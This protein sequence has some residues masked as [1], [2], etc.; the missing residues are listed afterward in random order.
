[1]EVRI[2]MTETVKKWLGIGGRV[3][4]D[5]MIVLVAH[6]LAFQLRVLEW[7]PQD[8]RF[9]IIVMA[10]VYI[11][12][13]TLFGIYQRLWEHASLYE[14]FVIVKTIGVSIMLILL[15][16]TFWP[17][18]PRRLSTLA[19]M[20]GGLFAM[21]G[22]I[23]TRYHWRVF[24][25]VLMRLRPHHGDAQRILI[26]GADEAGQFVAQ[27]IRE[28]RNR[29]QYK[30]LGFLDDNP[31]KIDRVVLGMRVL[32]RC[33]EVA[34]WASRM[35]ADTLIIALHGIKRSRLH[36]IIAS[37]QETSARVQISP[38]VL[39]FTEPLSIRDITLD[40]MI[41]RQ[42]VAINDEE[43]R[44]LISGKKVLVTGVGGSIGS[45]LARQLSKFAPAHLFLLDNN[46]TALYDLS[47][48]LRWA[49]P[50][51]QQT[52]I[53]CDV[54]DQQRV[55]RYFA[56][57]QPAIIFHVAAY[58]H[59]PIL[60][61]HVNAAIKTNVWGT[62][63]VSQTALEVGAEYCI[64]VSTDKAVNPSSMMGITKRLGELWVAA[65]SE[66]AKGKPIFSAVRFGNVIG[67]RGSV[68]PLFWQQIDRGGPVTV[69]HPEM[70]RFFMSI[71]EA[72]SL[73]VQAATFATGQDIF[74]LDMGEEVKISDLAARM[75]R[76]RGLR[77]GEDVKIVYTGVRPG[78]K[79]HE[80]LFLGEELQQQTPHP[81]IY[82]LQRSASW[83]Q[84]DSLKLLYTELL[85]INAYSDNATM[86][87]LLL[88][89]LQAAEAGCGSLKA[90]DASLLSEGTQVFLNGYRKEKVE[91]SEEKSEM[92][93]DIGGKV[94]I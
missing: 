43:C 94:Q 6:T 92:T 2:S 75:I 74:M 9:A 5:G 38:D 36:E 91:Y 18:A 50:E 61:E 81:R 66:S 89:F 13:G 15:A 62:M 35:Q 4:L 56:L 59:V 33:D 84:V 67:S 78:E 39:H 31:A 64:F 45:E 63:V 86:H 72:A 77:V 17:E 57:H 51:L 73:I 12:V 71:P 58:K 37:C 47:N 3:L 26:L 21:I 25:Q 53:L 87:Q 48:E 80:E 41:G 93:K 49:V 82:R 22:F 16:N 7:Q 30:L 27:R 69:T 32:G 76:L 1:L 90:L 70:T 44:K 10:L 46:E 68:V 60:E 29:I 24:N 55:K 8:Y 83:P 85:H 34:H 11:G 28:S 23:G 42:T 79:L 19:V 65:L 40:D 20:L 14:V 88:L 52:L 54:T